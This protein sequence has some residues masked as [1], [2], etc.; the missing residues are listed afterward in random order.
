MAC[1]RK[2][3]HPGVPSLAKAL[4]EIAAHIRQVARLCRIAVYSLAK[5]FF[6]SQKANQSELAE[7]F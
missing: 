1:E 3:S 6:G 4:P 7:M 2:T 5:T